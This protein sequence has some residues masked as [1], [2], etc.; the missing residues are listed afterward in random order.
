[1]AEAVRLV[2]VAGP[3]LPDPDVA[4]LER[5]EVS[6]VAVLPHDPRVALLGE[7]GGRV[8]PLRRLRRRRV[9]AGHQERCAPQ[10]HQVAQHP[11]P[12]REGGV[13]QVAERRGGPTQRRLGL[14]TVGDPREP[15]LPG[16]RVLVIGV[17]DRV[18]HRRA[19]VREEMG[20]PIVVE[21]G[22]PSVPD[23]L[24]ELGAV[25]DDDQVVADRPSG[26]ERRADLGQER[27]VVADRPVVVDL[28]PGF[29]REQ[30]ERRVAV[31]APSVDVVGPVREVDEAGLLLRSPPRLPVAL[32]RGSPAW[33]PSVTVPS[34]RPS[35][36]PRSRR[37]AGGV[38]ESVPR[39]RLGG[40]RWSTRT[41]GGSG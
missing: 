21:G 40:P 29:T 19:R 8:R 5:P 17:P 13:E 34:R 11:D 27:G 38:V 12:S 3:R 23:Q 24:R 25:R 28:D 1:M 31:V 15:G 6:L 7:Q 9:D 30:L 39:T 22:Q 14:G 16:D 2:D 37:A 33:R 35:S 41:S 4:T 32:T 26:G 10:V 36:E 18:A 20:E